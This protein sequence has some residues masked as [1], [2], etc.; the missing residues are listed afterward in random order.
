MASS[1]KELVGNCATWLKVFKR[2]RDE[3][4][5]CPKSVQAIFIFFDIADPVGSAVCMGTVN[6]EA[7][8]D[9]C[10]GILK[11]IERGTSLIINPYDV[12]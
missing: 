3:K 7:V 11:K 1:K 4:K 12:Q 5:I 9:A 6:P 10:K 2:E 8:K